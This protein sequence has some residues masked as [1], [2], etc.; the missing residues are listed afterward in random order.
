MSEQPTDAF[1]EHTPPVTG[2]NA[3]SQ[4]VVRFL[5]GTLTGTRAEE[6]AAAIAAGDL[7]ARRTQFR[8]STFM[9]LRWAAVTGQTLTIL[10]V[11]FG[12]DFDFPWVACLALVAAAAAVNL[13]LAQRYRG[14]PTN[15]R[16]AED[17][18]FP[19]LA[20]DIAQLGLLIFFTGGMTNP[21]AIFV[22]APVMAASTTMTADRIWRLGLL[23]VVFVTLVAFYYVPLPWYGL[24]PDER[25]GGLPPLY[26]GGHWTAI[27]VMIAFTVSYAFRAADEGRKL[28][29]ALAATELVLQREQHLSALDGLAAAAA[30]ELGTPLGTI[31][32]TAGEIARELEADD[33]LR[34]DVALIRSQAKRC[35]EI[36]GRLSAMGSQGDAHLA[37]VAPSVLVEDV[38]APHRAFDITFETAAEGLD[39]ELE[40]LVAR[41]PAI[42]FGLGNLVENAAEFARSRVTVATRWTPT[43]LAFEVSDDG[44][45]FAPET[46]SRLGEPFVSRGRRGQRVSDAPPG[47]GRTKS[48]DGR[49]KKGLGLGIFIAKTLLERTGGTVTFENRPG[50]Q[51]GARV[52]VAW[53]REAIE[54]PD[55]AMAPRAREAASLAAT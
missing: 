51:R 12:F 4:A 25:T 37:S 54:H 10:V 46:L 17:L 18:V 40:P 38:I 3:V 36:L 48:G 49:T 8:L 11:R 15:V 47:D 1:S 7:A 5:F 27:V 42:L 24:P 44:P 6:R 20:F 31:A 16:V 23:A 55:A 53:P 41:N 2:P 30:H 52:T 19:I 13:Y 21:F 45:G 43:S 32:M 29:D 33:P 22:M 35:R 34:E 26:I 9:R 28:A 14:H 39:E 50:P